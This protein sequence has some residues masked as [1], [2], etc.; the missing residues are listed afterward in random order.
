MD[1]NEIK[2]RYLVHTGCMKAGTDTW[3]YYNPCTLCLVRPKPCPYETKPLTPKVKEAVKQVEHEIIRLE[4][5]LRSA[6]DMISQK[7]L[8]IVNLKKNSS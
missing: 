2:C 7:R 6:Q 3:G 8:Q 1:T 5:G 4:S